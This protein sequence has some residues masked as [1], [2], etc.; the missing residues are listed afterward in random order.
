MSLLSQIRLLLE[1][2]AGLPYRSVTTGGCKHERQE[3]GPDRLGQNPALPILVFDLIHLHN[4]RT[5]S[6]AHCEMRV[7]I[8]EVLMTVG[9]HDQGHRA[10]LAV[11]T[12]F[13]LE[14]YQASGKNPVTVHYF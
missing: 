14:R 4:H 10:T 1:P 7:N 8:S 6:L 12:L 3:R 11:V 5:C 13:L 9:A 2:E